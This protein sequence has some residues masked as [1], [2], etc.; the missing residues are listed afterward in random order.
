M[1]ELRSVIVNLSE[2]YH[3]EAYDHKMDVYNELKLEPTVEHDNFCD[4]MFFAG[5]QA[6][7]NQIVAEIFKENKELDSPETIFFEALADT[8]D[9]VYLKARWGTKNIIGI[10]RRFFN[11]GVDFENDHFHDAIVNLTCGTGGKIL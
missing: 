8:S 1:S 6:R 3:A 4:F 2:H 11:R 5:V 10:G 7:K 9:D